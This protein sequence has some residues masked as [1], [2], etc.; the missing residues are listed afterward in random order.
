LD[1]LDTHFVSLLRTLRLGQVLAT[2][3]PLRHD[4]WWS[5]YLVGRN[6]LVN[7]LS[8]EP[9]LLVSSYFAT[10]CSYQVPSKYLGATLLRGYGHIVTFHCSEDQRRLQITKIS[11]HN[12][13]HLGPAF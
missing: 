13:H 4:P 8:L 7:T 10:P 11:V 1:D 12:R 9:I 3:W 2:T 5:W 6:T